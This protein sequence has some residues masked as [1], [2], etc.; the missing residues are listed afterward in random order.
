MLA[1][2]T[3]CWGSVSA[4][5]RQVTNAS[6]SL[7]PQAVKVIEAKLAAVPSNRL[8]RRKVKDGMEIFTQVHEKNS[9]QR[10]SVMC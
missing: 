4:G 3:A 2:I 6:S 10:L 1:S 9:C 7:P 5:T 8:R